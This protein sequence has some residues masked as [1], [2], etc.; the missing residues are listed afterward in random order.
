MAQ[1]RRHPAGYDWEG[2]PDPSSA[3]PFVL[4]DRD[5]AEVP[6]APADPPGEGEGGRR[7]RR[8]TPWSIVAIVALQATAMVAVIA[9]IVGGAL[10]V[11]QGDAEPVAAPSGTQSPADGPAEQEKEPGV[12]TDSEGEEL[13]DGTGGYDDPGIAGEHT[14]SWTAWTQGTLSVSALEIDL[15]ATLPAAGGEQLI[16][17]GYRLVEVGYVVRYEGSGQLA[18]VEELWLAGESDRAYHQDVAEGLIPDSMQAVRPLA[19]GESA[20]FR[21]LHV[22]PTREL[23]SFRLSVETYSGQTLYYDAR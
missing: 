23:E 11:L 12:V 22:V 1:Q 4:P 21:T 9:L 20:E 19:D 6:V 5:E 18:P 2:M 3:E 17:D 8:L 13:R 10:H 7:G 16:E 15:E 14:F